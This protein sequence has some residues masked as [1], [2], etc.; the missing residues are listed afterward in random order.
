MA[1]NVKKKC[2]EY[3][4]DFLFEYYSNS[5]DSYYKTEYSN[6][7]RWINLKFPV[8]NIL[9]FDSIKCNQSKFKFS[10]AFCGFNL[11]EHMVKLESSK[12]QC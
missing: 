7:I 10:S 11:V 8:E 2:K 5:Y 9:T 6:W 1:H 4:L 3:T 12:N